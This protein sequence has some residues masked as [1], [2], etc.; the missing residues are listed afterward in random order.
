VEKIKTR[1][2]KG[3]GMSIDELSDEQKKQAM[4]FIFWNAV[5]VIGGYIVLFVI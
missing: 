4:K 5:V 1:L 2:R 3:Q